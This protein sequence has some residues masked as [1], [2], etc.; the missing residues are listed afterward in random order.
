MIDPAALGNSRNR[1]RSPLSWF[2]LQLTAVPSVAGAWTAVG[3][4]QARRTRIG[5]Q[6]QAGIF[7]MGGE[8]VTTLSIGLPNDLLPF[9]NVEETPLIRDQSQEHGHE[10]IR[11]GHGLCTYDAQVIGVAAVLDNTYP[12][13]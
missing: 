6:H 8:D 12:S 9:E 2:G 4:A 10:V 1:T 11:F 13:L 3:L 5:A 7:A